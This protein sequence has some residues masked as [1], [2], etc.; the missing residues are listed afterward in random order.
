MTSLLS[1]VMIVKDEARGIRETLLSDRR[2]VD[3]WTILDTGSTDETPD[4]DREV[5]AGLP[6]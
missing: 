3:R 5:M 2:Q 4:V 1:L 6:G